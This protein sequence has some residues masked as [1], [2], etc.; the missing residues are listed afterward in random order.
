V[1]NSG[2]REA[3]SYSEIA[4]SVGVDSPADITFATDILQEAQAAQQAGAP[5]IGRVGRLLFLSLT[6]TFAVVYWFRNSTWQ[7][8]QGFEQ[9]DDAIRVL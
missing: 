9:G 2:K 6:V 5:E 1:L 4:L 7:D 8:C 3:K